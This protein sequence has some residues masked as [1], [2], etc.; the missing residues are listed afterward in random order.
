MR[1]DATAYENRV[2]GLIVTSSGASGE[3]D[4]VD[5]PRNLLTDRQA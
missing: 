2:P 3:Q 1:S 5:E 4:F